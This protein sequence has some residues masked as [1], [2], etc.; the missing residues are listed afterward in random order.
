[1]LNI[2]VKLTLT[3]PSVK[4]GGKKDDNYE[5]VVLRG[6]AHVAAGTV[7]CTLLVNPSDVLG[8]QFPRMVNVDFCEWPDFSA[9]RMM[10][11]NLDVDTVYHAC[12]GLWPGTEV[13]LQCE[14]SQR[15]G[16]RG[17]Q[18]LGINIIDVQVL[19]M[20]EASAIEAAQKPALLASLARAASNGRPPADKGGK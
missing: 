5:L 20:P 12:S 17:R 14:I 1:M 8:A 3:E 18:I 6:H 15:A 9:S 4:I 7:G 13:L 2:M 19:V 16:D 11:R 10:S